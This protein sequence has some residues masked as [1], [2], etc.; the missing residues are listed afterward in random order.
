MR[1]ETRSQALAQEWDQMMQWKAVGYQGL[2]RDAWSGQ[3]ADIM[4][5]LEGRTQVVAI[6]HV[7]DGAI[8][9]EISEALQL[10]LQEP[11]QWLQDDMTL[12]VDA[13]RRP[14]APWS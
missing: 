12:P 4:K 11:A 1:Y 9:S 13:Y 2:D 14:E 10:Y 3:S 7:E 5:N 8:I 6:K